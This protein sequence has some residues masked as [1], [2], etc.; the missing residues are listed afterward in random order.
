MFPSVALSS[1]TVAGVFSREQVVSVTIQNSFPGPHSFGTWGSEPSHPVWFIPLKVPKQLYAPFVK[2]HCRDRR[3]VHRWVTEHPLL[4][5][6]PSWGWRSSCGAF[7]RGAPGSD[8]RL[9]QVQTVP[10]PRSRRPLVSFSV[11]GIVYVSA[12]ALSSPTSG[13]GMPNESKV[14]PFSGKGNAL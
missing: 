1:T 12:P 4:R 6:L 10:G 3:P 13:W 14:G 9:G 5:S 2:W 7:A 11:R 8:E